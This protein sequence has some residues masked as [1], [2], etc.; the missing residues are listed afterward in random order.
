MFQADCKAKDLDFML[1]LGDSIKILGPKPM[2]KADPSRLQQIIMNLCSNAIKFTSLQA[3]RE[4]T[5]RVD[6]NLKA[7]DEHDPIVPPPDPPMTT[8]PDGHP[9]WLYVSVSD[10][11]PGMT[12]HE[13]SKLFKRFMQANTEIHTHMGGSGLGLFIAKQLCELQE[14]RIEAIS[15]K[16]VPTGSVFRFFIRAASVVKPTEMIRSRS[17]PLFP[18]D[19]NKAGLMRILVVDDNE[20]NRKT[21]SRQLKMYKHTV[22]MAGDGQETL[23]SN[24]CRVAMCPTLIR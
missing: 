6:V 1:V 4:V 5:I 7:P 22:K 2:I 17:T 11:G 21:L 14:G 23:V 3:K 16:E 24:R 13:L 12:P 10:T 8:L 9:I 20:I 18:A 19:D 15:T